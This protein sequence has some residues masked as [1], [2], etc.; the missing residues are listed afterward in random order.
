MPQWN[1]EAAEHRN[2]E[3]QKATIRSDSDSEEEGPAED[4]RDGT[5]SH[6]RHCH[7]TLSLTAIPL[8]FTY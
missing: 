2:T 8:G 1:A 6:G 3:L 4:L 5:A 7:S